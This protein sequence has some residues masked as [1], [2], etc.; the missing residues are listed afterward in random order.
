MKC[1][2]PILLFLLYFSL[3]ST[4]SSSQSCKSSC[5]AFPIHFPFG[6]GPGC[7]SPAFQQH[8][9]C[10]ENHDLI[11][12]T[13]TGSYPVQSIDYANQILYIQ[14]PCMSTCFITNP[15]TGFALDWDA[16]FT[17]VDGDI[18]ALLDCSTSSDSPLYSTNSTNMCDTSNAPICS[19]LYTCPAISQLNVPI[20]TCCIYS[21]VSLGP[22]FEMDLKQLHCSSYT[23]IYS[24]NGAET[25][26]SGW[27]FGIAL[28]YRFSVDDGYPSACADCEKSNGVCGYTGQS[29]SF[30]CNCANGVNTTTN[31]YYAKW[32]SGTSIKQLSFGKN[33]YT[34][35]SFF[36]TDRTTCA[37]N[38]DNWCLLV[39]GFLLIS[40]LWGVMA[41]IL[42]WF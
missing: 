18:F 22:S 37:V 14:D 7:G 10:N 28:K 33:T 39:S 3:L 35:F 34:R 4:H 38:S 31:C 16:P 12:T 1:S 27:K 30:S 25:D 13:H 2:H 9:A 29:N 32:N 5:G 36:N 26:P 15:S 23:G 8:V 20:S 42:L 17:F 40:F 24:F 11:F 6:T 21:P 41:W 19:L